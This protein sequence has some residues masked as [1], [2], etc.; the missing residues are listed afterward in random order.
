MIRRHLRGAL[1]A[2]GLLVPAGTGCARFHAAPLHPAQTASAFQARTLRDP[3]LRAFLEQHLHHP[4]DPWPPSTW[5][6]EMLVLAACY[7]HPDMSIA[8]S[9]WQE[10]NGA[11]VTAGQ[12]PNPTL[13]VS[14]QFVTTVPESISPWVIGPTLD[15]PVETAG[16]RRD[17]LAQARHHAQAIGFHRAAVA[18][19][20]RS[21]LRASLLELDA[22]TQEEAVLDQQ[23]ASHDSYLAFLDERLASGEISP[24]SFS[25][26]RMAFDR[27][28]VAVREAHR[29]SLEARLQVAE[30][31]GVSINALSEIEI[32][33]VS[34]RQ[35][36]SDISLHEIGRQALWRRADLLE[37]LEEYASSE[38][39]LQLEIAKQ[40]PDINLGPAYSW[41]Q[42]VDKWSLG[43]S[44]SLPILNHNQGPIAEAQGRRAEAAARFLALQAQVIAEIERAGAAYGAARDI[45]A[46]ADE[47]LAAQRLEFRLTEQRLKMGEA[48]IPAL[49]SARAAL[50]TAMVDRLHALIEAQR[51]FGHMEDAVQSPLDASRF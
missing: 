11:I 16:K 25:Q 38:A 44:M 36:L 6:F 42:D 26:T 22:A 19:Q 43:V 5:D 40:Y 12:R 48:T 2:L 21:R 45:L 39:A 31:M 9:Q 10:A 32:S 14:P 37:S 50:D 13:S 27:T 47:S 17:R 15:L 49:L 29:R 41:D 28:T 8:D 34:L 23:M 7:D 35:P 4:I 51:A 20:V 33:S 18:W 1:W 3:N 46:A 30:A 24:A